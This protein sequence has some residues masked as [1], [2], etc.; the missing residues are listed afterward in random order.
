MIWQDVTPF[1]RDF[2]SSAV[3]TDLSAVSY[4][5]LGFLD[6]EALEYATGDYGSRVRSERV[7]LL[8]PSVGLPAVAKGWGV[9]VEG[10]TY[11]VLDVR[12]NGEGTTTIYLE[13]L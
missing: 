11:N 8:C 12:N 5:V 10:V 9:A 3:L 6:R 7:T 4:T 2:A 1:F 13:D